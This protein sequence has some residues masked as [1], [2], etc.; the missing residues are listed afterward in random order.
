MAFSF[1]ARGV[2]LYLFAGILISLSGCK[3]D[4]VQAAGSGSGADLSGPPVY[5]KV[6]QAREPRVC[7]KL[8]T[9]PNASQAA[10]LVQ[11]S[12]EVT[13]RDPHWAM[14]STDVVVQMG[15]PRAFMMGSDQ[16]WTDIDPAGKVIP[17]RGSG[18]QWSC[19]DDPSRPGTNCTKE[20]GVVS[21]GGACW[22]TQFNDWQCR[23][24]VGGDRDHDVM[25]TKGPMTY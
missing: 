2:A 25:N 15:T 1:R 24:N 10:A 5:S 19:F 6:W 8:T 17:L 16:Y 20:P 3:S 14:L 13:F 23:M 4:G 7:S 9:M 11:C 12:G 22:H 18:T 21:S